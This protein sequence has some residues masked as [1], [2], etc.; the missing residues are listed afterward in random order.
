MLSLLD[1]LIQPSGLRALAI[2][3]RAL[4]LRVANV[5]A[6]GRSSIYGANAN[7]RDI[8]SVAFLLIIPTNSLNADEG[9]FDVYTAGPRPRT[10]LWI[11]WIW[12]TSSVVLSI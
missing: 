9:P 6:L 3:K 7:I 1:R 5:C 4:K 10:L 8:S 2:W 12:H 11:I